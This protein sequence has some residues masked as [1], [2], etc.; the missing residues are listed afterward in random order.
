[1]LWSSSDVGCVVQLLWLELAEKAACII[2][3]L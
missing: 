1:M 3:Q 2:L